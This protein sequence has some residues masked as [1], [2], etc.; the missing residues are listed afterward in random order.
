MSIARIIDANANRAREALRV[1]ED[2][3]RFTFD[4]RPLTDACKQLRHELTAITSRLADIGRVRDTPGDVGTQLS[5]EREHDR[6][7][8]DDVV[9]A[10]GKRL[11][12]ALRSLEE[13]TKTIDADAAGQLRQL[14]YRGYD[15]EKQFALRLRRN[16]APQWK[17]CLLL[18]ADLCPDGNWH[19]VAEAALAGGCDC[20]QLREKALTDR[21]LLARAEELRRIIA[22]R[23]ALII[24]D[25]A[26]IAALAGADGVHLGRGDL[27][28]VQVRRLVGGRLHVG[29]S[30]HDIDEL[31]AAARA[32][33]D[34]VGLGAMFTSALKPDRTPAGPAFL[35]AAIERHPGLPHLAIGGITPESL[36]ELTRHGCRG[37]AVST[38][39][40]RAADPR[41]VAARIVEQLASAPVW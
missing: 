16:V 27:S 37:V 14:R 23:A 13:Y 25:R 35:S 15:L 41:A 7:S 39:I 8:I 22:D 9:V 20:V 2:A 4:D 12:E 18:T 24:N 19:R 33:A 29:V 6:A 1:L 21:E 38:A 28:I 30:A 40:C 17:L 3:A 5:T 26:D 32:G 36:G 31:D 34:Y 10:A 11:G